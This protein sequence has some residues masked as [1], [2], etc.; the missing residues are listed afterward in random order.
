MNFDSFVSTTNIKQANYGS[1]KG[2]NRTKY[3][4]T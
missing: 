3:K 4:L 2:I 1:R